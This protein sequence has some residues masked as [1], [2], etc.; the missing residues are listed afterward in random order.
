MRRLLVLGSWILVMLCKPGLPAQAELPSAEQALKQYVPIHRDVDIDQP[1]AAEAA[2]C[3]ISARKVDGKTAVAIESPAGLLLRLFVDVDGNGV[4]DQWRYFKDGLEVYRDIDSNGN[5]RADQYRWFHGAGSRWGI[6]RDENGTVD[7]WKTISAEEASAEIV[8]ALA[9]KDVARFVRVALSPAELKSLGLGAEKT[10]S[11][12]ERLTGLQDEFQRLMQKQRMVGPA[13]KWVQFSAS[14]PGTVPAGTNG[15]INDLQVYENVV[16][17]TETDGVNGQVQIGTLV[18][19]GETWRAIQLPV[20]V[21]D[22][23]HEIAES[24]EFFNKPPVIRQPEMPSGGPS[25]ELQTA[26]A[27]LQ[28]LDQQAGTIPDGPAR[29][30]YHQA[31][32]NL[33]QEIAAKSASAEEQSL[34]LR[35]LADSVSAAVQ[36]GEFPAGIER[37][38]ALLASLNG[39]DPEIEA[40]VAFRKL[41]AEYG[42]KMQNSSAMDFAKVHQEWL[43]NLREFAEAYPDSPDTAEA[44]LQLAMAHEFAG[45]EDKAKEWY[46]QIA[47]KFPESS[48]ARKAAGARTRLDCVGNEIRFKGQSPSGETVDLAGYRGKVVVI[49]YWAS[50]CEPCKA[51]M[52]ALKDL[53]IRYGKSG[54]QVIGV[55][56]DSSL[57]EMKSY[58]TQNPLPWQQIHEQ[59]G[60]DSRPANELGIH[61]LPTMILVDQGGKVVNRN[62]HVAELD[63]ELRKLIR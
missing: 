62:V 48:Q 45:E 9:E 1:D 35:Q 36:S 24:G 34:W 29:G 43:D 53:A 16:A 41:S 28:E 3:K 10:K 58:L 4:V 52:A 32:A 20:P 11:L 57:Q 47:A 39:K 38:G 33:L 22:G 44:M 61:T 55:N 17:I 7:Y 21:E 46:G 2:Q 6:D 59:G 12:T 50:W 19:V 26:L 30:Q 51:D 5:N 63:S 56:V 31:R 42:L 49:Q 8:A 18:K 25:E 37:L 54:F 14:R 40:Y 27:K 13:T 15:S 23:Q 60:L